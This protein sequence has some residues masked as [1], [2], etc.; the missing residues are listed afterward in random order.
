[1]LHSII[2]KSDKSLTSTRKLQRQQEELTPRIL[3][4]NRGQASRKHKENPVPS[5]NFSRQ[6]TE[7]L[8]KEKCKARTG[9]IGAV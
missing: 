2:H 5:S 1:M 3:A 6:Q 8:A 4:Q 9:S 7:M